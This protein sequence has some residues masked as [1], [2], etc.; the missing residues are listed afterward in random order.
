MNNRDL[1]ISIFSD[2][3]Y[4][5][6][7]LRQIFNA[8]K[9]LGGARQYKGPI[10]RIELREKTIVISLCFLARYYVKIRSWEK[11]LSLSFSLEVPFTVFPV[12]MRSLY[13]FEVGGTTYFLHPSNDVLDSLFREV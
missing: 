11:N 7:D 2:P 4:S 12:R 10:D 3:T 13:K 9:R 8:P 6:G 5:F 1:W